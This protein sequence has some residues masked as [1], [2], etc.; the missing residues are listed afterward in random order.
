MT[1]GVG[2]VV[3]TSSGER[4]ASDI[5]Q[6]LEKGFGKVSISFVNH[7]TNTVFSLRNNAKL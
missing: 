3:L 4:L 1:D 7:G 6:P 5:S 2:L